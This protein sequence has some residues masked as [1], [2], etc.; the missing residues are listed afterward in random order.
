MA[1]IV[2]A[3]ASVLTLLDHTVKT[4]SLI[5]KLRDV[6]TV[7]RGLTMQAKQLEEVIRTIQS[8]GALDPIR[9][10]LQAILQDS[11]MDLSTFHKRLQILARNL[12]GKTIRRT[13]GAVIGIVKEKEFEE[14]ARKIE[15]HKTTLL[16]F[17]QTQN[18]F[19]AVFTVEV[20]GS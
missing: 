9:D 16:L 3:V 1:E 20:E 17:L 7:V 11:M 8:S 2:G 18:L 6:P 14:A 15:G 5:S 12:D 4:L 13:W 19:V 10:P